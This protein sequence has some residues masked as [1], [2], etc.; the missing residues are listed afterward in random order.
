[1]HIAF[2]CRAHQ[3]VAP[4]VMVILKKSLNGLMPRRISTQQEVLMAHK[5]SP[6]PSSRRS[7]LA[8]F[9]FA[10]GAANSR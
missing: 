5:F 7:H 2:R 9:V 1:M 3:P 10:V 8:R 6:R 4:G